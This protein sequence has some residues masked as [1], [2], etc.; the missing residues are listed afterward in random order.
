MSYIITCS[1]IHVSCLV[2][3]ML[4]RIFAFTGKDKKNNINAWVVIIKSVNVQMLQWLWKFDYKFI[5]GLFYFYWFT[6]NHSCMTLVY[7]SLAYRSSSWLFCSTLHIRLSLLSSYWV[8]SRV[9]RTVD[10]LSNFTI[11]SNS[12]N[13]DEEFTRILFPS[14]FCV[15]GCALC[16]WFYT[17][18]GTLGMRLEWHR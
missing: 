9:L 17:T 15:Y 1:Y 10:L 12:V 13:C 8:I 3:S 11:K 2:S 6:A 5:I 14:V 4:T 16:V 18:A 7:H